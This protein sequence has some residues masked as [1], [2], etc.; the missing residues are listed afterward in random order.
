MTTHEEAVSQIANTVKS[1]FD[2]GV[3]YRIFHGSM[4]STRPVHNERV[5]DISALSNV[6][7][8]DRVTM[9]AVVEPN[10]PMDRLVRAT[11]EYGLIPSVVMV[12][13][14]VF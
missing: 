4:N 6:L 5:V 14:F 10:V 8:V 11:L 9:T 3:S 12:S 13:F 1:L 7:A 2:R